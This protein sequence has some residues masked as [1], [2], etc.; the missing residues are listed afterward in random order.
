LASDYRSVALLGGGW[1]GL[2]ETVQGKKLVASGATPSEVRLWLTFVCAMDR[3]RDADTL[4]SRGVKAWHHVQW[5]FDPSEVV[6]RP[7]H[8][9][10]GALRLQ[11]LSQRHSLDAFAWRVIAEGLASPDCQLPASSEDTPR[12]PPSSSRLLAA[13]GLTAPGSFRC[14]GSAAG[15]QTAVTT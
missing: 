6:R 1:D 7:L 12:R 9:L 11:G 3:A 5:V 4:W 15:H 13:S 10:A 8:R 14:S 2:P